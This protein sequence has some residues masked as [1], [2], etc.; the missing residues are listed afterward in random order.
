VS[1]ENLWQVLAV[2]LWGLPLPLLALD[3]ERRR[4]RA[5]L[6]QASVLLAL[7][8]L[9]VLR[10]GVGE[11]LVLVPMARSALVILL[12]LVL[13]ESFLSVRRGVWRLRGI[14]VAVLL[15]D[16]ALGLSPWRHGVRAAGVISAFCLASAALSARTLWL[17]LPI[18]AAAFCLA[19]SGELPELQICGQLLLSF[20]LFWDVRGGVREAER[21]KQKYHQDNLR[22]G[23]LLEALSS[24]IPSAEHELSEDRLGTLLQFARSAIRADG[25]AIFHYHEEETSQGT[26]SRRLI[27]VGGQGNLSGLTKTPQAVILAQL[28]LSRLE[29]SGERAM[30]CRRDHRVDALVLDEWQVPRLVAALI[31]AQGRPT[32]VLVLSLPANTT[33][34]AEEI[35]LLDFISQQ[36][37]FSLHYDHVYNLMVEQTRLVR[38]F[39]IAAR[40]QKGLLPASHIQVRNLDMEA[41]MQAARE[42]GGDYY[43]FI[44]LGNDQ[45]MIVI[46]D[47]AGKGLPAGMIMLIV[48]TILHV[49]LD[50]Q[51]ETSPA[52]LV[53][54]L[55]SRLCPQLDLMTYVT[56]LCLRWNASDRS[57]LWCGA[58]H[59]HLLVWMALEKK[60]WRIRSGGMALGLWR[61]P[62]GNWKESE[63]RMAPGD[64]I[65]LYTDGVTEARGRDGEAF[66]LERLERSLADHAHLE[67][68]ELLNMVRSDLLRHV[69]GLPSEDDRTLLVLKIT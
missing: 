35:G 55:N 14:T 52:W 20:S 18:A 44:P 46:G 63:L 39:D 23:S 56:F 68:T 3:F 27:C 64:A 28:L 4:S 59:E 58:G 25:G 10:H 34:G 36:A 53:S 31:R 16:V 66:G 30:E 7:A 29:A 22:H 54:Q 17:G 21:Q 2:V 12:A 15:L 51:S 43:D 42:V 8:V 13:A 32:G 60:V 33:M 67:A 38:E 48:R 69:G 65:L 57:F 19:G 6:L 11:G 49:L 1:W 45:F 61:E 24:G 40:L 9:E 26:L 5:R 41:S 47:V 50:L 37:A 62:G